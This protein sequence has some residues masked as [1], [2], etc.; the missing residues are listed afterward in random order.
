M[1]RWPRGGF[2]DQNLT[3]MMGNHPNLKFSFL[4]EIRKCPENEKMDVEWYGKFLKYEN[5]QGC[6]FDKILNQ[7]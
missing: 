4:S 2:N 7:D 1:K 5:A 6:I 3:K